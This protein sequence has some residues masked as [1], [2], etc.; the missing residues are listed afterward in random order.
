MPKMKVADMTPEEQEAQRDKWRLE[1]Q[2]EREEK[3]KAEYIPTANEWID[4]FDADFPE[5]AK[6]LAAHVKEFSSKV[7]EELGRELGYVDDDGYTLDRV[8]RTLLG[9]KKSW[10]KEVLNGEIVAGL[11]F[12]DSFGSVVESAHRYGLKQ[13]PTFARSFLELLKMLNKR[14]GDQ[15]TKDAA[16]IRAELAGTYVPSTEP[17]L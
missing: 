14:Y 4:Q 8:A 17:K 15:K 2:A 9:L 1:K 6:T 3:R 13:S 12:A 5:Q 10:V 16:V 7:A 11:Y